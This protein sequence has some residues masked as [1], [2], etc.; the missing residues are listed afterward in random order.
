[1]RVV[2]SKKSLKGML[3]WSQLGFFVCA[4]A[5]LGYCAFVLVDT[6][7]FQYRES[8]KLERLLEGHRALGGASLEAK[9]LRPPEIPRLPRCVDLLAALKSPV[10]ACP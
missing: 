7:A 3:R 1:M 4:T 9:L 8:C 5:L 10:L 2:V 6:R